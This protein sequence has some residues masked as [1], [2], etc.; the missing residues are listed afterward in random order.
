[1]RKKNLADLENAS[2]QPRPLGTLVLVVE[3]DF[4]EVT[5]GGVLLPSITKDT[6]FLVAG[7]VLACGEG[8]RD[9]SELIPL[10][11][12]P[13]D[14]VLY[15]KTSANVWQDPISKVEYMFVPCSNM[16]CVLPSA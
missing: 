11:V 13:G 7:T 14:R 4:D 3:E 8:Y 16:L 2:R 9:G 15:A 10:E 5:S 1:M 6:Q 12:K